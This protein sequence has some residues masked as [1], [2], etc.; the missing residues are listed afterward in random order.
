MQRR[1]QSLVKSTAALQAFPPEKPRL[2][3]QLESQLAARE[4]ALLARETELL[5]IQSGLANQQEGIR[6]RERALE[7]AERMREREAALP[8][9]PY[10]SF[11]EGLDAFSGGRRRN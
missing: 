2:I 9:V 4:A 3:A 7:D 1:G 5:R 6:R 10:V 11:T 8:A